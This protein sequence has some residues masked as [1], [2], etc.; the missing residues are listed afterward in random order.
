MNKYLNISAAFFF[1]SYS[2]IYV[3][4][5]FLSDYLLTPNEL[6]YK[7]FGEIIGIENMDSLINRIRLSQKNGYFIFPVLILLRSFYTAICLS[8]GAFLSD[9]NLNLSQSFNIAL[10]A[11]IIFLLDIIVKNKL[12]LTNRC[13][14]N[15]IIKY[16]C[17][18]NTAFC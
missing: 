5:N 6:Y 7:S 16:S 18:F 14:I 13:K 2:I 17:F 8:I 3:F 12:L 11:D 10:K 1:L 15:T 9:L 4:L